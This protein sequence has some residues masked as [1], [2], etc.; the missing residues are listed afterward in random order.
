MNNGKNTQGGIILVRHGEAEHNI[1]Q[2]FNSYPGNS[3]YKIA[4]LTP[5]G[6]EQVEN[7]ARLMIQQGVSRENV[8]KIISSPLPRTVETAEILMS[9]L[10]VREVDTEVDARLIELNMGAREGQ[11]ISDFNDG[12]PWFPDNPEQ[13]GGENTNQVMERMGN[14]LQSIKNNPEY[15]IE[16]KFII[17]ISHGTPIFCALKHLTGQGDRLNTA[18]YRVVSY[19]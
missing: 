5:T 10:N 8:S 14:L 4:R 13:F 6:R 11:S 3:G 15:S 19:P 9:R 2:V 1:A 17:I 7:T 12:D 16:N 18:G